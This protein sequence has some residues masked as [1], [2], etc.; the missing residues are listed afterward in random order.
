MLPQLSEFATKTAQTLAGTLLG[1]DLS[2]KAINRRIEELNQTP[3]MRKIMR[4]MDKL[5]KRHVCPTPKSALQKAPVQYKA[6]KR[7]IPKTYFV[8]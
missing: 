6:Y 2:L 8:N 7:R 4:R 5:E 1:I 3:N